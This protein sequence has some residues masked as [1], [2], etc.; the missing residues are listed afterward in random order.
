MSTSIVELET[1]KATTIK[2]TDDRL[3]V[4]IADGRMVSVPLAWYPRLVHATH[5]E[6]ANWEL[7]V[8][9]EH[10][11]WPDL[12]EDISVEALLAGKPSG[13]SERSFKRWLKAKQAGRSVAYH[14]LMA[15]KK[16]EEHAS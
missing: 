10:I 2:T 4:E 14:D 16:A 5:E 3:T 15:A 7:H 1:P 8:D 11:H 12:D 9:G 6:R 13:E